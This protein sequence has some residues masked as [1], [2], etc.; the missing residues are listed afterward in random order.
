MILHRVSLCYQS[1][2]CQY[3][4]INCLISFY[5]SVSRPVEE[6]LKGHNTRIH[7][8]VTRVRDGAP[9][10]RNPILTVT[11]PELS[12]PIKYGVFTALSGALMGTLFCYVIE[13]PYSLR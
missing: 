6:K 13:A 7:Q 2:S 4:I 5:I 10:Y 9:W 8:I 1:T 12:R 11:V 3:S